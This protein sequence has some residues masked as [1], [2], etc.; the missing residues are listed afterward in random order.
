M[1][2]T[3]IQTT[4]ARRMEH[5]WVKIH[6]YTSPI[7]AEMDKQFLEENDIPAIVMNQQDSSLKFGRIDLYVKDEMSTR[8]K[9]LLGGLHS[10]E[11]E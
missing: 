4:N 10:Q 2:F 7:E 1:F 5:G 8:A 6:N 3:D 9:E 11:E